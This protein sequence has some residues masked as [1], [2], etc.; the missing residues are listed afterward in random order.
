MIMVSIVAMTFF[1]I[2]FNLTV[3]YTYW[4]L[5]SNP[6]QSHQVFAALVKSI[7]IK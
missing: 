6:M 1:E 4:T 5:D 7:N 3:Q 2:L